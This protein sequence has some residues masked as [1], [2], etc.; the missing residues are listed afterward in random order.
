M[1]VR[2]RIPL[3]WSWSKRNNCVSTYSY[4]EF[5]QLLAPKNR[6]EIRLIKAELWTVSFMYLFLFIPTPVLYTSQ[7]LW[8][9]Q[10][11]YELYFTI[12]PTHIIPFG[13]QDA[14]N[15]LVWCRKL[16]R[17]SQYFSRRG[18]TTLYRA[19]S[20]KFMLEF[21]FCV[22][23]LL[24]R[25]ST[26][27]LFSSIISSMFASLHIKPLVYPCYIEHFHYFPSRRVNTGNF[28]VCSISILTPSNCLLCSV[29][30]HLI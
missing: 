17:T 21:F 25:F 24:W 20:S 29:Y 26:P 28:E 14:V 9:P 16:V 6:F 13:I 22:F 1:L 3:S 8:L 19:R 15:L 10:V 23:S 5:I 4:T 7:L 27:I 2:L 18:Y 12:L 11:V 30:M